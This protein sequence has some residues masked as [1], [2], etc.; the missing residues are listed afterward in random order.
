MGI[1]KEDVQSDVQKSFLEQIKRRVW[2]RF[3]NIGGN[4]KKTLEGKRLGSELRKSSQ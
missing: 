4:V 3:G 2:E 1:F